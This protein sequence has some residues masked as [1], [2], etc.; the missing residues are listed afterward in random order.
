MFTKGNKVY[1]DAGK[2]LVSKDRRIIALNITGSIDDYDEEEIN[3]PLDIEIK[4]SL[5]YYQN[6]KLICA[7][8]IMDYA[9]IK[10][11]MIKL[12]YSNDDQLALMLNKDNSE[13]DTELYNKMQEWREWSGTFAKLVMSKIEKT[14]AEDS[15][16]SDAEFEEMVAE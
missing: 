12:R 11:K 6:R 16:V 10:T 3:S 1:A 4:D 2:Y 13:E 7:P 5:I 9:G 8:E 15:G 14:T